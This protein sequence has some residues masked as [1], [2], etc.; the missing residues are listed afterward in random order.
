LGNQWS[1]TDALKTFTETGL[2]KT[3]KAY[4]RY[5]KHYTASV[6]AKKYY[7]LYKLA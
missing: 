5:L 4:D 6:M 7:E 1:L 2:N 3:C